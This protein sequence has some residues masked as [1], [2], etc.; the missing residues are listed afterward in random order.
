M[1]VPHF[2]KFAAEHYDLPQEE[3]END[4]SPE[5]ISKSP[6]EQQQSKHKQGGSR[7]PNR[8]QPRR[9]AKNKR[10]R[11]MDSPTSEEEN[12]ENESQVK[13]RQKKGGGE[14]R[15]PPTKVILSKIES[16]MTHVDR[17]NSTCLFGPK[18]WT[19]CVCFEEKTAH[20]K[21]LRKQE[22]KAQAYSLASDASQ[23]RP[24]AQMEAD[25]EGDILLD[26]ANISVPP[27]R[28]FVLGKD[29]FTLDACGQ[30]MVLRL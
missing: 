25:N 19:C 12:E 16:V 20:N 11:Y 3:V 4:I 28:I 23:H 13:I 9:A 10:V 21:Q 18:T 22:Q 8:V 6:M 1:C 27:N 17:N 26:W 24:A 29:S 5:K 2:L 15:E 30:P 14:F 7:A